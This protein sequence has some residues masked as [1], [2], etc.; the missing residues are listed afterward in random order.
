M[1]YWSEIPVLA[2]R[3][4]R[5]FVLLRLEKKLPQSQIKFVV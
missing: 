4:D 1:D 2:T 3:C 5:S